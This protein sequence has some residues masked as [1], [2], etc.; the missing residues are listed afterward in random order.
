MKSANSGLFYTPLHRDAFCQ[1]LF[2]WIYYYGSNKSTGKETAKTH[3]CALY[4]HVMV[5]ARNL[6]KKTSISKHMTPTG[7]NQAPTRPTLKGGV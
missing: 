4:Y 6:I 1:F 5:L 2:R 3:L 7:S